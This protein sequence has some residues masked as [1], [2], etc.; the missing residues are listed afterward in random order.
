MAPTFTHE[1][2]NQSYTG[3]TS[4]GTGVYIDGQFRDGSN[5]TTIDVVNPTNGSLITKIAEATAADVNTAVKAAQK[6]LDTTWGLNTSG[7]ERG[8]LIGKLARLMERDQDELSAIEALDN[9]KTFGWAKGVDIAFS[10]QTIKYFAGWA[11]KI[12]G[13]TIETDEKKLVY[14]R[15]EPLGVV[16]QIIPWNFPLLM[17]AWK[18]AP[19]LATGNAIVIKTH[20]D[21]SGSWEKVELGLGSVFDA[22]FASAE[23]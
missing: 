8:E 5:G 13:Q 7:A 19:A 14:T 12:T 22:L 4:F 1:F 16:G 9:G 18:I 11:D 15:H 23:A 20:G 10:I 21:A 6:A 2:K 3:K 17:F